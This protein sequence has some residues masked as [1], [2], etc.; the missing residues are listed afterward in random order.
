MIAHQGESQYFHT[1]TLRCDGYIHHGDSPFRVAQKDHAR[2]QR[3]RV[4]VKERTAFPEQSF[5]FP[6]IPRLR[7]SSYVFHSRKHNGNTDGRQYPAF[8][9]FF[10]RRRLSVFDGTI[11]P[12]VRKKRKRNNKS[13]SEN[14]S[15][16]CTMPVGGPCHP[17][18]RPILRRNEAFNVLRSR[19]GLFT[20]M[21]KA[22]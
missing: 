16:P 19:K 14:G 3:L 6:F 13:Y 17:H 2:F 7:L 12:I 22:K 10:F 11:R 15:L 8:I 21:N 9:F 4:Q 1:R 20:R 18:Y 5:Q